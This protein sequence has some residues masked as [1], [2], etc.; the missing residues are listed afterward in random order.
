MQN[1]IL[2]I[3]IIFP[4]FFVIFIGYFLKQKEIIDDSFVSTSTKLVFYVA[5]PMKLFFDIK[6]YELKE[7]DFK[8]TMYLLIT[9]IITFLVSW[10][11]GRIFIKDDKKLSAFVHCVYR[12][13]FI[14]IGI[15]IIESIF[16]DPVMDSIII[17]I[18]F[19]LTLYNILATFILTYYGDGKL[20]ISS[21][22]IKV[23][24]NPM[25]IGT[26]LGLFAKFINLPIYSGIEDGAIMLSKLCT[27]LSLILIGGSLDFSAGREDLGIVL[28]SSIIKDAL[29]ALIAIPIGVML[30]FTSSQ[31]VV[32]FVFFASPCAVNCFIMGKQMGSDAKLTSK[33][34][35]MSFAL[36]IITYSIGISLL[37]SRGIL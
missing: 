16:K 1:L 28:T 14:Y 34:V 6:N 36:S 10:I 20:S 11:L 33:I 30:D 21:F 15:P 7:I 29:I 32:A 4:V 3:N 12:S 37:K 5:L 2:G 8:Y 26:L 9:I 35:T 19:G 23:L 27:P 24:K 25:I 18:I 13:N 17:V 22:I 31:L